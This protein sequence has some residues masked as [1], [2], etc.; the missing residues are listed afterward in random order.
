MT[1]AHQIDQDPSITVGVDTHADFHHAVVIEASGA[2]VADRQFS[3]TATG[4]RQLCEWAGSFGTITQV[5]VE[6]TGSYGAGLTRYAIAAGLVVVEIN[7]PHVH[8]RARIGKSDPIDAEAAARKAA[9]GQATAVAKD[10]TGV[11]ESIRVVL[12][13][14]DSA[15]RTRTRTLLQIRDLIT[16]APDR[17]RDQLRHNTTAAR[18]DACRNLCPDTT[19]L[20]DPTE[21]AKHALR[22]LARRII[23]LN[24][25]IKEHDQALGPLVT[26]NAPTLLA[27][28]QIGVITAAQLLVSAGQNRD[29]IKTEAAFARLTGVAPIPASSGKTTRMRLHRGGDR[30]ANRALHL[31]VVGRLKNHPPTIAYAARRSA[32][33]LSKKDIIRC[34]KRYVAREVFNALKTDQHTT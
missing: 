26:H 15:V 17:L 14:R 10:T 33:G 7:Q 2:R 19:R 5:A 29:R 32:E 20:D 12:V 18:I 22:A 34:L 8:T 21:A 23:D 24:V 9:S 28:P 11:I 6:S 25:E 1:T 27:R 30:Q 13:A 4:Y 31:I 16:T 3:A